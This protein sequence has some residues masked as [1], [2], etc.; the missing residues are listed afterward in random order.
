MKSALVA[1]R[2]VADTKSETESEASDF[3]G[4]TP[5]IC[6]AATIFQRRNAS[7]ALRGISCASSEHYKMLIER[8]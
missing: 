3:R 7:G 1:C 6:R 4:K 8:P 5:S 2:R